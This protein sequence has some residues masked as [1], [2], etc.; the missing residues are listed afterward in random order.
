LETNSEKI[1]RTLQ[2][3]PSKEELLTQKVIRAPIGADV[4]TVT[5]GQTLIISEPSADIHDDVVFMT[6]NTWAARSTDGGN[7]FSFINPFSDFPFLCCDQ[8]VVYNEE[9]GVW[10]WY[11]QGFPDSSLGGSGF[12]NNVKISVSTDDA[13]SWCTYTITASNLN[14]GLTDH[15]IDYPHLQVTDDKLYIATNIFDNIGF[16]HFTGMIR[17]DLSELATCSALPFQVFLTSTEFNFTPV[18]GAINTMYFGTQI[19]ST[20]TKIYSWQDSSNS[21]NTNTVSYPAYSFSGYS[22]IV[23]S[24]GTNPCGRSDTR[25]QGGYLSNGILGF[26]WDAAQGGSFPYPYVNYI[27]VNASTGTLLANIPL[28]SN[29]AA[30]NFASLGVTDSG[31]IGIGFSLMGGSTNPTFIVGIDDSQTGTNAFDFATVKTSSH[32]PG[33]TNSWGDYIR[34]KPLKPDNG[35]WIGTGFTMQGGTTNSDVENLFLIFGRPAPPPNNPPT[36]TISSPINGSEFQK[37]E[38][39]LFSGNATDTEDGDISSNL[40]WTS[41]LDG[42]IGMGAS[43]TNHTLSVGTHAI[44]AFVT[45]SGNASDS[46]Q[47]PITILETPFCIPSI[48]GDWIITSNCVLSENTSITGNVIV[49]NNSILEIPNGVTL[50]IDFANF[51]LTVKSGSGVLIKSGGT[52]T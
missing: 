26:V 11:R 52:I 2:S 13:F 16:D 40:Q 37:D 33:T 29:S 27:T 10:I 31:D 23:S 9:H 41:D 39:I 19:S 49:Q 3:N 45:D 12:R 36:V 51:N 15:Y 8:D 25:I 24:T 43:F 46:K 35:L 30:A 32:G 4:T 18:N 22:C 38:S 1:Q 28:F 48:S 47:I 44:T 20:Q 17:F 42:V 5:V 34:I 6:G 7:N 21:L 14:S 50:D